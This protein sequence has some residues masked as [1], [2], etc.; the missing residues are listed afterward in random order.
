M[1]T[2]SPVEEFCSI[3]RD[4]Q[5]DGA[6]ALEMIQQRYSI[7]YGSRKSGGRKTGPQ[8]ECHP[9]FFLDM[10]IIVGRPLHAITRVNERFFDNVNVSFHHWRASYS[11]KHVHGLHFDLQ[12]RT[13]RIAS[14]ATR[15]SWFIV[16]HPIVNSMT[17]ML[18]SQ[19][20]QRRRM[21]ESS[22]SSALQYHHA[23]FLASYIKEI[24]HVEEL[25]G[26]GVE[27][28]WKLDGAQ[29]QN[30]TFNKWTIFQEQFMQHWNHYIQEHTTDVFWHQNQPAF[31]AYDY[32]AN[33][34]IVI[35]DY[36]CSLS[37]EVSL[38]PPQDDESDASDDDDRDHDMFYPIPDP[39]SSP[40][41]SVSEPSHVE[42]V[43]PLPGLVSTES[44]P[45]GLKQLHDEL[46][47]KYVVDHIRSVSFALAVDINC[48]DTSVEEDSGQHPARC[49]LADRNLVSKEFR[50]ARDFTF[51]PLAFHPAYGNFSSS[52][53]PSFLNDHVLAVGQDNMSYRN[54]G[55]DALTYGYFQA[56]SNIKR[57]IRHGPDDLLV[58][59][60][61]ATGGLTLSEAEARA[62][63]RLQSKRQKL[64]RQLMG[65]ATPDDPD[66][67]RPFAREER[68]IRNLV[69]SEAFAFRMEQV[70][71]VAMHRLQPLLRSVATA[72]QPIFQLMRFF[73][74]EPDHYTSFLRSFVPAA[75]PSVL[76]AYARLFDRA[77]DD[78]RERIDARGADGPTVAL[79]EGVAALDRLGSYCFTG[80]PRSL[81]GTILK[82]LDTI[83]SITYNAWPYLRPDM[84][85]LLPAQGSL[86]LARWPRCP[87]GRPIL[88]HIAAL[89]YHYGA[90]AALSRHHH[91]WFSELGGAAMTSPSGITNLLEDFFDN[92]W[93]PQMVAF[94]AFQLERRLQAERRGFEFLPS[95][96]LESAAADQRRQILNTWTQSR[97]PFSWSEYEP[98]V[99]NLIAPLYRVPV[100]TS[101]KARQDFSSELYSSGRQSTARG[102]ASVTSPHATWLAVL[103]RVVH[104]APSSQVSSENW[105]AALSAAA[106]SNG[107][108][109]MPGVYRSRLSLCRTVRLI[110]YTTP[111]VVLAAPPGSLKR[112]A[113]EAQSR[114]KRSRMLTRVDFGH[115]VPFNDIPHLLRDGFEGL[116]R[117]FRHGNQMIMEHYHVARTCLEGCLGDPLCDL[118]L[119][120]VLT[121]AS[122]SVT[123]VIPSGSKDFA[124]GKARDPSSFAV[125]LATRM[126]WYLRPK[127]FPWHED[128]PR[129]LRVSEMTKKLEHKGVNNRLLREI[130]WVKVISGNRDS[131]RNTDLQ[132]QDVDKL[133]EMR[134]G[135]L[136][137]LKDPPGFIRMVFHSHD[138]IWVDRCSRII[139]QATNNV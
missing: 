54:G 21:E 120:I 131:P 45:H 20:E 104:S 69:D 132:L 127:Q 51:Y 74:Q 19:Q 107:I 66:A 72:L 2:T 13:F 109:C 79:A 133:M 6:R 7:D 12:H 4:P 134:K 17:E 80:F 119:M 27:A 130:R 50:G 59:K 124:P 26:E 33:I 48:L 31:H 15:E 110:G 30:I 18:Q 70:I 112:A 16:M 32:G 118:L 96:P 34:P 82:P 28:S 64:R 83:D 91:V 87:K 24:F 76:G 102:T 42:N 89:T 136:S 8:D 98:I 105:I 5:F 115:P 88:L 100:Q 14:A 94:V 108:E 97:R 135:L 65:L 95:S 35:S 121:L 138:P 99:T 73:L 77:L 43:T 113:M 1:L 116:E 49:L 114:A 57:S 25:L 38:R 40:N 85:D 122:C 58:T 129:V 11:A 61:I 101:I 60:G 23:E 44:F 123:P 93:I 47:Q 63:I 106:L 111:A 86:N 36:V 53:P 68:R 117:H 10:L 137:S 126:L 75:F 62:S 139:Q 56:Y 125:S 90:A 37:P 46:E 55:S 29:S 103:R 9:E 128:Q 22:G 81:M 71:H 52:R 3:V 67:S 78:L 92:L 41:D 84:L 39:L